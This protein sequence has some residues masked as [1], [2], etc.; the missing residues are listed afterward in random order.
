MVSWT[1]DIKQRANVATLQQGKTGR[2]SHLW[3]HQAC[4][5]V[6]QEG[7]AIFGLTKLAVR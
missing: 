2:G 5:E 6:G 3:S 1:D 4:S 7:G